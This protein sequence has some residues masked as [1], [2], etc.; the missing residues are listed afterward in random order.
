MTAKTATASVAVMIVQLGKG[1]GRRPSGAPSRV[2]LRRLSAGW[3]AGSRFGGG[4]WGC[5]CRDDR[6]AAERVPCVRE[7]GRGVADERRRP[8]GVV[9]RVGTIRF[10]RHVAGGS[11]SGH[12]VEVVV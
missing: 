9:K 4:A 10:S 5:R 7:V 2:L 12:P 3:Y 8:G 6:D 11:G 1:E